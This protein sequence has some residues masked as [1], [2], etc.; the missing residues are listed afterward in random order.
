MRA[1]WIYWAAVAVLFPE[2]GGKTEAF[3]GYST[4]LLV[5]DKTESRVMNIRYVAT[6][7][8]LVY[9]CYIH[10]LKKVDMYVCARRRV[11]IGVMFLS[12]KTCLCKLPPKLLTA[13]PAYPTFSLASHREQQKKLA[14]VSG[15]PTFHR[16]QR[17]RLMYVDYV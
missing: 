14:V 4:K 13:T 12:Q 6:V 11:D 5:C 1:G 8:C 16:Q 9:L 10:Q 3:I 2:H 15:C 17:V 7:S